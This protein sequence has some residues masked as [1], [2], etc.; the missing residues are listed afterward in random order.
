[1]CIIIDTNVLARVFD[2]FNVDHYEFS[3]VYNWIIK[4]K[5]K[6]VFGGTK[7]TKEIGKYLNLF[8]ELKKIRKAI[9]VDSVLVD[10]KEEEIKKSIEKKDFDD[11]H[12]VSLLMV[13]KCQLICSLDRR[14]YPFFRHSNYFSPAKTKPRIYSGAKNKKLLTNK[15]IAEICKPSTTTTNQQKERIAKLIENQK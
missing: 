2:V 7:Y 13:S 12:L 6:V 8:V 9:Y 14:A 11:Q 4:G 1:M 15:Y 5:G 3:P 10:Q